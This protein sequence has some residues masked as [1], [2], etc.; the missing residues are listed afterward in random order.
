MVLGGIKL[1]QIPCAAARRIA[2]NARLAQLAPA[3]V[4]TLDLPPPHL[5]VAGANMIHVALP[6]QEPALTEEPREDMRLADPRLVAKDGE[7]GL[8]ATN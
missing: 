2:L 3:A 4:L 5:Q 7:S 8:A 6:G 1:G